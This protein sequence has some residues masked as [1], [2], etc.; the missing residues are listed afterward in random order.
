M[1]SRREGESKGSRRRVVDSVGRT[2]GTLAVH[3]RERGVF[4]GEREE[5]E[6]AKARLR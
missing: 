4:E 5:N 2:V 1:E 6:W 3:R